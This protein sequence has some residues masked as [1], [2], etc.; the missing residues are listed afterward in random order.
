MP[1]SQ[2]WLAALGQGFGNPYKILSW[3]CCNQ[4]RGLLPPGSGA[5]DALKM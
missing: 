5:E 3:P 2:A 4:D 1:A